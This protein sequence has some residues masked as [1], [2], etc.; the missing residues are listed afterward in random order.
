MI[1]GELLMSLRTANQQRVL[2]LHLANGS[3]LLISK[4]LAPTD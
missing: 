1:Q 3:S 4:S 2:A